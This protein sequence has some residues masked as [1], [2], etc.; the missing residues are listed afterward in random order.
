MSL[1]IA[2]QHLASKGR[3]PDT[4]LVHMTK[5]EVA[6]L[7]ALAKAGGGSLTI[8][9]HTGLAEAGFLQSMLPTLI[10]AGLAVATGGTS[11]ALTPGMI[12]L[13]IGGLQALRT[14]DLKQGLMA[15][16]GAYGGAGLAA[17]ITP[18]MLGT[19]GGETAANSATQMSQ[20]DVLAQ[21]G[22]PEMASNAGMGSA[23][24]NANVMAQPE[25]IGADFEQMPI[26]QQ[27]GPFAGKEFM[28]RPGVTEANY[29]KDFYQTADIGKTATSLKP[30]MGITDTLAKN[31]TYGNVSAA[32][33]P[34]IAGMM[35][36]QMPTQMKG[37]TDM[38]PRYRFDAGTATPQPAASATGVE[39]AYFPTQGYSRVS[40][41][42]AKALYGYADG[43]NVQFPYGESVMRMARGGTSHLGDYSDGG[44]LLRGPGDGVSDSIP[45]VIGRKQPARLADGE[46]VVPAR[47]VSELGNGS[48]EAGA[49][50][51]YKMMDRVQK[52]RSKTTGKGKIAKNT[53]AARYLP[54]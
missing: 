6:G 35:T 33:A 13:G 7:Q 14:G 32:L 16:L 24:P 20:A 11:L 26:S 18:E 22:A 42:D 47:I 15:G 49:R 39:N 17:G 51:L 46:F 31:A 27:S 30:E 9:P 3:G 25:Y 52:S 2:A 38:G 4:E 53:N 48:T 36:P 45:A 28:P 43:G 21:S 29:G 8:N 1:H 5:G 54:A 44:R 40:D 37:D 34:G 50:Q 12:G 41:A 10:G 19:K 23:A